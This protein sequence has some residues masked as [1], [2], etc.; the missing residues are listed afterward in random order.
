[1]K[2]KG[3][4]GVV[5]G[6]IALT[7]CAALA[8]PKIMDKLSNQIYRLTPTEKNHEEEDWGPVIERRV[9]E[10]ESDHDGNK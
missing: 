7:V 9:K 6:S 3:A 10:E 4:F 5:A 8:L 2:K 1:M